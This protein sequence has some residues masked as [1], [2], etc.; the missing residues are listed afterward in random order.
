MSINI[1]G[2]NNQVRPQSYNLVRETISSSI[3]N[4]RELES[5]SRQT[6]ERSIRDILDITEKDHLLGQS[7][8]SNNTI[9]FLVS[10]QSQRDFYFQ[11]SDIDSYNFILNNLSKILSSSE[12]SFNNI[13]L[14]N[15]LSHEIVKA[16]SIINE[17]GR[18]TNQCSIYS[19]E[20]FNLKKDYLNNIQKPNSERYFIKSE[21]SEFLREDHI[22]NLTSLNNNLNLVYSSIDNTLEKIDLIKTNYNFGN[23]ISDFY[24]NGNSSS[25]LGKLAS[26]LIDNSNIDLFRGDQNIKESNRN[27]DSFFY[28]TEEFTFRSE[29][30]SHEI[31]DL[32]VSLHDS[33]ESYLKNS[34]E[35]KIPVNSDRLIGQILLNTS[36]SLN[37]FYKDSLSYGF[38]SDKSLEST[39]GNDLLRFVD[40]L[41]FN[42]VPYIKLNSII[43]IETNS[44][45][46]LNSYNNDD[47]YSLNIS[48][49]DFFNLD[50]YPVFNSLERF[51]KDGNGKIS[52][53]NQKTYE[54]FQDSLYLTNILSEKALTLQDFGQYLTSENILQKEKFF[55][56]EPNLNIKSRYYNPMLFPRIRL[57][58]GFRDST[59]DEKESSIYET[60]FD[61][62]EHGINENKAITGFSNS[63]NILN[64][65][66]FLY[67]LN[68]NYK[69]PIN[70][71]SSI[72]LTGNLPILKVCL[73]GNDFLRKT[74]EG[75]LVERADISV[76]DEYERHFINPIKFDF[77]QRSLRDHYKRE[78]KF[79]NKDFVIRTFDIEDNRENFLEDQKVD[80]FFKTNVKEDN[81]TPTYDPSKINY[82]HPSLYNYNSRFSKTRK[83]ISLGYSSKGFVLFENTLNEFDSKKIKDKFIKY[84]DSLTK[85]NEFLSDRVILQSST[86]DQDDKN[87]T[88]LSIESLKKVGF[89][90]D[91]WVKIAF[92]IRNSLFNLKKIKLNNSNQTSVLDYLEE[93]KSK[94]KK[95]NNVENS[96]PYLGLLYSDLFKTSISTLED[97]EFIKTSGGENY[98]NFDFSEGG[99]IKNTVD[100]FV[101]GNENIVFPINKDQLK[102]FISL[103]Y[104]DS[105]FKTSSILIQH[106]IKNIHN[107]F[108]DSFDSSFTPE[109]RMNLCYDKLMSDAI[110]HDQNKDMSDVMV[111]SALMSY[112]NLFVN[113]DFNE[114]NELSNN[115]Y[116]KYIKSVYSFENIQRQKSYTLRTVE[117]PRTYFTLNQN[118]PTQN[119]EYYNPENVYFG[120]SQY[121]FDILDHDFD[122]GVLPG[123]T[124]TLSFPFISSKYCTYID[125]R[126]MGCSSY[127][128]KDTSSENELGY[129]I[130]DYNRFKYY[131]G[132]Y[133][134]EGLYEF[135]YSQ[136][137]NYDVYLNNG[138]D[139]TGELGNTKTSFNYN[140]NEAI[141]DLIY[142]SAKGVNS[143]ESLRSFHIDQET[144]YYGKLQLVTENRKSFSGDN[145][146]SIDDL[147]DKLDNYYTSRKEKIKDYSFN[148]LVNQSPFKSFLNNFI[149][150]SLK[151]T[152]TNFIED[153]NNI[154]SIEEIFSYVKDSS[155]ES[156]AIFDLIKIACN[157]YS[158]IF[159]L[160][161]EGS[162]IKSIPKFLDDYDLNQYNTSLKDDMWNKD[163]FDLLG[164]DKLVSSGNYKYKWDS[165]FSESDERF[166]DIMFTKF[167]ADFLNIEKSL[168]NSDLVEIMSFDSISSYLVELEKLNN[169]P[170]S[171]LSIIE[172]TNNLDNILDSSN[173][174]NIIRSDIRLNLVSKKLNDY[175]YYQTKEFSKFI[176][177]INLDPR[178]DLKQN[179]D[180]LL[181]DNTIEYFST[182]IENEECISKLSNQGSLLLN[183]LNTRY[184]IIRLGI[185]YDLAEA[186]SDKRILKLKFN[187]INHKY[188]NIYIPSIYKF[189]TPILTEITPSHVKLLEGSRDYNEGIFIDDFIAYYD[190]SK[191]D[192]KER[193]NVESF[194]F[195]NSFIQK[196]LLEK[197]NNERLFRLEKDILSFGVSEKNNMSIKIVTDS[198]MSNAVKYS[199]KKTQVNIDENHILSFNEGTNTI[200]DVSIGLFESM[201]ERDFEQTFLENYEK[202]QTII[203]EIND[204]NGKI[205]TIESQSH[206]IEFFKNIS[207]YSNMSNVFQIFEDNRLYDIFSVQIGR[208]D[209]Y[210]IIKNYYQENEEIIRLIGDE[211]NIL[212]NDFFDSFSYIIES[213]VI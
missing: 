59:W 105:E 125:I 132:G 10:N 66:K 62:F 207:K 4:T 7:E 213:E 83:E 126:D 128:I 175:Y 176:D 54:V 19:D 156:K 166:L 82:F 153:I 80:T 140:N 137:Y 14:P 136:F 52:S 180:E 76:N 60:D 87:D 191:R 173:T 53:L 75:N 72:D 86:F 24:L 74:R 28:N 92:D 177:K 145:P 183:N 115:S 106:L 97:S 202:S 160:V 205:K 139:V 68:R 129:L 15:V 29:H 121:R 111:S 185:D 23:K 189:Y 77:I 124:Y 109:D 95:V 34:S 100:Y 33:K 18:L 199:N 190:T 116:E 187:I 49:K 184:D 150:E 6:Q 79:K 45:N 195:V 21:N 12:D 122:F 157:I 91:E 90:K 170:S 11:N 37:G 178:K 204:F 113:K 119:S 50:N 206:F 154:S 9:N 71:F 35:N 38:W 103:Y 65:T 130:V 16:K 73:D 47:A 159:D 101:D 193:Y 146:K 40:S 69:S 31:F 110:I 134:G 148:N 57:I 99:D 107:I 165:N 179:F 22:N 169:N 63:K 143:N 118:F 78:G 96:K 203:S 164:I 26:E 117:F 162:I 209:I 167:H 210:N 163:I 20:I 135:V 147:Q 85:E 67:F 64:S 144:N 211:E 89:K 172:N 158:S 200:E 32:L 48:N 142:R 8:S 104:T 56:N 181:K 1:S 17:N 25:S 138:V 182:F 5:T 133:S 81:F 197:V 120:E 70:N 44:N 58:S 61:F 43:S 51:E 94:S 151:Y 186:L 192:L 88:E 149:I 131:N 46:V 42:Q 155:K 194:S 188:P 2:V 30:S 55:L 3:P 114:L 198:L 36:L 102:D 39:S 174:K 112:K 123:S 41:S 13:S 108:K 27:I 98:K 201:S 161:I 152:K 171:V 212:F 84:D 127:R 196:N 168:N 208:N 141:I 93:F